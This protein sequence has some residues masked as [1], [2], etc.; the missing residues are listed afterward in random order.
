MRPDS[1]LSGRIQTSATLKQLDEEMKRTTTMRY[2]SIRLPPEE[3]RH[4]IKLAM[5]VSSSGL[6]ISSVLAPD[7]VKY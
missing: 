5:L 4:V 6:A 2:G 7:V 3:F 1:K